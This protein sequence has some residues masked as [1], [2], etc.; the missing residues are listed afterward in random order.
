[1][2]AARGRRVRALVQYNSFN[3]WGW[4][5]RSPRAKDMDVVAGDVR[6][7]HFC[8]QLMRDVD[9][10]FHLA[11]LIAIPYS[12]VAPDSYIDTNV[13]GTLNIC[14]AAL[15]A[16]VKR[17]IHTS[18]S[19]VY[20]TAQYV[21]IDE[22]HP[23]QPQSPYSASKIG[24]DQIALSFHHAFGLP[25]TV[26]RPFN[27]YGPRQS[28]RAVIPTIISQIAAGRR[29]ISLGDT[30]PTRDFNYVEDTCRGF[31]AIAGADGAAGEVLNIGSDT[32]IS[33]GDTFALI[34]ELMGGDAELAHDAQRVRPAGSEVFRL[35]CDSRKLRE[36]TG[37]QSQVDLREGL[38]R[39]IAWFTEPDN[40][41]AYKADIY[42]V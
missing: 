14:Q 40:L 13:K 26:A 12:Y 19:E 33:I 1:M 11:A 16:G 23:L 20:G 21:P 35:R 18:T 31:L 8:R 38:S 41:K 6:D 10:V 34:N 39:T 28:A 24:A 7:P 22:K 25:V 32:E 37:F 17:V 27:T 2:L 36:L 5:D 15:D 42:N 4:L 30:T 3:S 29:S 9:T